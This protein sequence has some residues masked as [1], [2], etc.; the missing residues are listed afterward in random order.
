MTHINIINDTYKYIC[1]FIFEKMTQDKELILKVLKPSKYGMSIKKIAENLDWSRTTV[2]KYLNELKDD[3]RVFDS[4]IG[5]YKLWLYQIPN[6]M[7]LTG[8][9]KILLRAYMSFLK[10]LN[11]L[12]PEIK[13]G[14]E[15]GKR[16]AKDL[17]IENEFPVNFKKLVK[18][19]LNLTQIAKT[20]M[21][22][23]NNI[24]FITYEKYNFDPPILNKNPPF[25]ILRIKDSKYI[26]I[27]LH[28]DILIGLIEEKVKQFYNI[29][30]DIQIHNMLLEENIIDIKINFKK[31]RQ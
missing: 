8:E 26:N 2:T 24:Y 28:F 31:F 14:K 23:L 15:I 19:P 11:K 7:T 9:G 4:E 1:I 21:E 10:N 29:D 22:V 3:G 18:R 25:I 30:V 5:Q 13:D 27:P 17:D 6:G 12:H 20:L 16:I